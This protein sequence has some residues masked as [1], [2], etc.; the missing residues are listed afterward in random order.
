MSFGFQKLDDQLSD[1]HSL[2][3]DST[4]LSHI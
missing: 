1:R 3:K 4:P 2:K